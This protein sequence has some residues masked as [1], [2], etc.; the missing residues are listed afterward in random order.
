VKYVLLLGEGRNGKSV[1]LFMLTDLLGVENYSKVTRQMIAERSP[2]AAELNDKLLNVVFD[3]EMGYIKD[4]SM[5]KTL[6]AGEPGVIRRLYES[7]TTT[8]QTN[9]LFIEGLQLEPKVRDKSPALQK[10]LARFR[11]PK[12]YAQDKKF[13]K[14]MRSPEM[15]GA[16]LSVLI[17]HYVHEDELAEKLALTAASLELQLEQVFIGSPVLQFLEHLAGTDQSALDKLNS[18]SMTTETFLASFKPWAQAQNLAERSDSDLLSMMKTSFDLGWKTIRGADKKPASKR[19]IKAIRPETLMALEQL[20]GSEE[21]G[22]NEP[23]DEGTGESDLAEV[24]E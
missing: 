16:F 24:G 19:V 6:I 3:G 8:V 20:K 10:R 23:D 22:S 13:A 7:G 15:L 4:S 1:L 2:V 5:E 11:F 9:A 14:H 17:D 18:G 21:N 12:V